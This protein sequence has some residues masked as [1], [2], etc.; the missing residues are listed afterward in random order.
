[1]LVSMVGE[2]RQLVTNELVEVQDFIRSID[3]FREIYL[4]IPQINISKPKDV[5]M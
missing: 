1:M 4:N 2:I 3:Y 5:N